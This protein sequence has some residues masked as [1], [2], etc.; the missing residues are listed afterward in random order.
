MYVPDHFAETRTPVLLALMSACP[1][2]TVVT[3][4]ADGMVANHLPLPH[5]PERDGHGVLRGHV[6]RAN[7]VWRQVA[8]GAEVLA[9]F[10]GPGHYISPQWYPSKQAHGRAVPTWNYAVVHARG[11]IGWQHDA[12]WLRALVDALTDTHEARLP[13]RWKVSDAPDDYVHRLIG[14]IVGLEIS[15]TALTG[16]W[17]VSQNRP[18]AD[19]QG[20][21]NG[22]AQAP[23]DP[24]RAMAALVAGTGERDEG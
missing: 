14:A 1:L 10:Q 21:L 16:K 4:G 20:V 3:V 2:A 18:A 17:K 23:G 5:V 24:A 13:G 19:R 15:I 22:L 12:A 8:A 9:V 7:P 6:A 11:T